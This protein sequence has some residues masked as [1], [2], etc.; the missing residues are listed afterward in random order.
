MHGAAINTHIWWL[1][2]SW[3]GVGF[4]SVV[5]WT[6]FTLIIVTI[7]VG[8]CSP[9]P[10]YNYIGQDYTSSLDILE[11]SSIEQFVWPACR[12][13]IQSISILYL[14]FTAYLKV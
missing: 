6:V 4:T 9:S 3:V 8:I 1:D 12:C 5:W 11:F 10:P 13:I 7:N 14:T 2:V